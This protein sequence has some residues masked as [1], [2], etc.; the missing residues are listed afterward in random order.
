MKNL[1]LLLA[2][3][4]AFAL[5]SCSKYADGTSVHQKGAWIIPVVGILAA[6]GFLGYAYKQS[7]SGSVVGG[8]SSNPKVKDGGGNI[9][10]YKTGLPFI[11][12]VAA[13]LLTILYFIVQNAQK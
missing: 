3:L 12:G 9:P 6:I 7:K 1:K 4:V 2:T 13:I 11:I 8:S 5:T 10:I